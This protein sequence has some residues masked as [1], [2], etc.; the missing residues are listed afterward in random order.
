M[1]LTDRAM[2]LDALMRNVKRN[3][4]DSESANAKTVDVQELEWGSELGDKFTDIQVILGADIVYIEETFH[5]LLKTLREI[6]RRNKDC[7]VLLSS[8]IRYERDERFY[9]MMRQHFN[10]EQVFY[11]VPRDIRIYKAH[12]L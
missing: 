10:V 4:F 12:L 3:C 2:A 6:T 1:V 11:D 5:L 8:K 7:V 9:E